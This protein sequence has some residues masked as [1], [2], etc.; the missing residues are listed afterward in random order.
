[1]IRNDFTCRKVMVQSVYILNILT[2]QYVMISYINNGHKLLQIL[3][4]SSPTKRNKCICALLLFYFH[5]KDENMMLTGFQKHPKFIEQ[6]H[7]N[8][9]LKPYQP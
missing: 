3:A 7:I 6:V 8:F 4:T 5:F 9:W 2:G 1:M